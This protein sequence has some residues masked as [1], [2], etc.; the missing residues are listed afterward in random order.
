MN[1]FLS[2]SFKDKEIAD[3]VSLQIKESN[4][5]SIN[6]YELNVSEVN[7]LDELR[8]SIRKS[9]YV[10]F[11]I[12]NNFLNSNYSMLELSEAL[13]ELRIRKINIIP[14]LIEK[15]SIPR[16]FWNLVLLIFQNPLKKVW[17]SY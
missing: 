2:Y 17:K 16:D 14:I 13:N 5:G 10:I 7:V 11:F 9:D 1:L 3:L 4:V 6:E 8:Y 12:S 15:C